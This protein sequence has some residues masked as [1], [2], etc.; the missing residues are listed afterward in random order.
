MVAQGFTTTEIARR[1]G[2]T[3]SAVEKVLGV[4]YRRLNVDTDSAIHPRVEAIR[5]FAAAAVLPERVD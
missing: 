4:I 2:C 3:T 1:R 5:I